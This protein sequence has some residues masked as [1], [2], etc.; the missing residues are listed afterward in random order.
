[1]RPDD[2]AYLLDRLPDGT[3]PPEL[4]EAAFD[5]LLDYMDMLQANHGRVRTEQTVMVQAYRDWLAG[6]RGARTLD[7]L[8]TRPSEAIAAL[9]EGQRPELPEDGE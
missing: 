9:T 6:D 8:E 1:V 3:I 2:P 7:D 4:H 5:V